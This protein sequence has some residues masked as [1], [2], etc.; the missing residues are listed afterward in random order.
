M[1]PNRNIRNQNVKERKN[2]KVRVNYYS[3]TWI[4][5]FHAVPSIA[6][7]LGTFQYLKFHFK[8]KNNYKFYI[9]HANIKG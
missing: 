7:S 4:V 9:Q 6:K 2:N 8:H 3:S 5:D 1:K